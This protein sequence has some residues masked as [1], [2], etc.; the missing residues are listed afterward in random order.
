MFWPE[1]KVDSWKS[2]I[3]VNP[4]YPYQG[5]ETVKNMI[6]LTSTA[7]K[8]HSTGAFAFRPLRMKEDKTELELEFHW[9]P[10]PIRESM[11]KMGLLDLPESTRGRRSSREETE[12]IFLRNPNESGTLIETG[13]VIRMTT[14]DPVIRPLPDPELIDMQWYLQRIFAMSGAADWWDEEL[15]SDSD[16]RVDPLRAFEQSA[17]IDVHAWLDDITADHDPASAE[18]SSSGGSVVDGL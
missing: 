18:S 13:R 4:N 8:V 7:H 6:T 1:E 9:L 16:A 14:N 5:T 3:F 11:A 2:K 17:P 15:E 10:R 12:F